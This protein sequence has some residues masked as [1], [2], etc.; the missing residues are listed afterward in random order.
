MATAGHRSLVG[1]SAGRGF[2]RDRPKKKKISAHRYLKS[3]KK[4][5]EQ[6]EL[7][8]KLL[9]YFLGSNKSNIN[10]SYCASVRLRVL[11]CSKI[12]HARRMGN[13]TR[14]IT[15]N[16]E[17]FKEF[18][19]DFKVLWMTLEQLV[20]IFIEL[21]ISRAIFVL[22]RWQDHVLVPSG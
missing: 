12:G 3:K 19:L 11:K 20:E 13:F 16:H 17:Y 4:R 2:V 5:F 18:L 10:Q 22:L 15:L 6:I 1:R 9:N 14:E 21:P 8:A 7:Q